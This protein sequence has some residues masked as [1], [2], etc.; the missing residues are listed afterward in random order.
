MS[1]SRTST[2]IGDGIF[3]L[4]PARGEAGGVTFNQRIDPV[5]DFQV[6]FDIMAAGIAIWTSPRSL[7]SDCFTLICQSKIVA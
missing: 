1:T 3:L 6:S 2:V 7:C 4:T 5:D